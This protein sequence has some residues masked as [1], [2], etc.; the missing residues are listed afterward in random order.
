MTRPFAATCLRRAFAFAFI[1]A[2]G[3]PSFAAQ[4]RS[5]PPGAGYPARPV[6]IVAP[7]AL[8][9][10]AD[11]AARVLAEHAPNYLGVPIAVVNR[12]G[13]D[14][15]TGSNYVKHAAPGGHLLIMGGAPSHAALP[16]V[17]PETPYRLEDFTPLGVIELNSIGCAVAGRGAA[18]SNAAELVATIRSSPE[19]ISYA[20]SGE[21]AGQYGRSFVRLAGGDPGK[22]KNES[23]PGANDSVKAVVDG[24][25]SFVC[26]SMQSLRGLAGLGTIKLL[27]TNDKARSKDF[28]SVPT[29]AEL[30]MPQ[31][32]KITAW[33]ALFGPANLPKPVVEK[34]RQVL[35]RLADDKTWRQRVTE[36]GSVPYLLSPEESARF[37]AE[38]YEMY[39]LLQSSDKK[40]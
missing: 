6:T 21:V 25:N 29:A 24:R 26:A 34:W 30:N 33:S 10:N 31:L 3:T 37:V 4:V 1:F 11:S 38:Q 5:D 35:A 23:Y 9:G 20:W 18:F 39:R 8:G 12:T 27:F 16:A 2:A 7:F 14:G 32:E 36:T 15:A 22:L 19:K 13:N 28:A 17:R 40:K